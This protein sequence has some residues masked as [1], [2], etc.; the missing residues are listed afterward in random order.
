MGNTFLNCQ[1]K[2]IAC[3]IATTIVMKE[4]LSVLTSLPLLDSLR[5]DPD[6]TWSRESGSNIDVLTRDDERPIAICHLDGMQPFTY[7]DKK[8]VQMHYE[9]ATAIALAAHHLNVGDGSLVPEVEGLPIRCNIRFTVEFADTEYSPSVAVDHVLNITSRLPGVERKPCAF[10]GAH[11]SAISIPTSMLTGLWNYPQVSGGST[12]ADLDDTDQ[13]PLFGRTVPSDHGNAVPIIQFMHDVLG[14]NHLAVLNV[15]DA[16]GNAFVQGLRLAADLL[17]PDMKIHQVPVDEGMDSIRYALTSIK[18]MQYK[19]IFAILFTPEVHDAVLMEAFEMGIAGTGKHTWL[20]GD[21]FDKV[22]G[23]TMKANSPLNLAYRGV[24]MLEAT[25]GVDGI[26]LS[27]FDE[28]LNRM[29]EVN[30]PTDLDYLFSLFPRHDDTRYQ[31]SIDSFSNF[32]SPATA[33][34]A[35][36]LYEATIAL[37]LAACSAV[38]GDLKLDGKEH[39]NKMV[40]TVFQ[41]INEYVVFDPITGSKDPTYTLYKVTNY[42]DQP[43]SEDGMVRF[44]ESVT[45]LYREGAWEELSPFVFNDGSNKIP[46]DIPLVILENEV[47][48]VGVRV[49]VLVLCGMVVILGVGLMA[50]THQNRKA[51]VV[52]ASQPFF[53]HIVCVGAIV[54]ACTIIPLSIDHGLSSLDGCTLACISIPWLGIMGFSMT[55]SALFTKTHRINMILN[56][57][58][59]MQRIKVTIW[60]VAK[61]MISLLSSESERFSWL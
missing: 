6:T 30:N 47:V 46:S 16:Y 32:L 10:I 7:G 58:N 45:H 55:V 15:N 13:Y 28:F 29:A 17:A 24:G 21:S 52:L 22:N 57:T 39:F 5:N 38:D 26:G 23:R 8:A 54:M 34:P 56:N 12:S 36:F 2:V 31:K 4:A 53:L 51:R 25:G 60:D 11:R 49:S 19:Y 59:R 40:N 50:W 18:E 37:G 44:A 48:H 9:G 61:P 43:A 20:F 3:A 14:I 1:Q 42:V 27:G 35:P 41:G 33:V